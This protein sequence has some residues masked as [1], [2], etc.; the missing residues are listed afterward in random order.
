MIKAL[1]RI[2]TEEN[3]EENLM[4]A[5]AKSYRFVSLL[6][7]L[8]LLVQTMGIGALTPL[9]MVAAPRTA[10][11]AA[12]SASPGADF[13]TRP[14][15][16]ETP[17]SVARAQST[18]TGETVVITYTVRNTLSPLSLPEVADGATAAEKMTALAGFDLAADPNAMQNVVLVA[19]TTAAGNI[20]GSS[21]PATVDTTVD[22]D[23][24]VFQLGSLPPQAE[25]TLVITSSAP[26]AVSDATPLLNVTGWASLQGR[27]LSAQA[28]PAL[29][30]SPALA[31]WLIR[32]MDADTEDAEM[33]AALGQ[34][35]GAPADI[36]AFVRGFG[37][38]A[39]SG[40]LRGTRG[41]LW[42]EAG[43]SLDQANLLI[44]ML[45]A[46]GVPARYRHGTL[47]QANAQTLIASMF[48]APASVIGQVSPE[49]PVS[50][51]VNDAALIGEVQDHWW[52][53]AYVNG[54]WTDLDP[55]F[56]GASIG[57]RFTDQIAGDGTDR[58]AEVPDSFRPKVTIRLDVDSYN[59]FNAGGLPRTTTQMTH[60]FRVV[61][62][63][64]SAVNF[65][66]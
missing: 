62:V 33:L 48:R 27:A 59:Q 63:A 11:A 58:V 50:D 34:V 2:T 32:T 19:E 55:S 41:T 7:C 37:F 64:T 60:T 36:F 66:H 17:L 47:S 23:S 30:H 9:P 24:H 29:V 35:G 12:P 15:G 22:G 26:A 43:N 8:S 56:V 51:P 5:V 3:T 53:E 31:S 65:S 49:I 28:A 42:S 21:V 25:A 39:Y 16:F 40:S 38:E 1:Q 14:D 18:F 6:V 57:Q 54:A 45:R 52:V 4:Y 46:A 61:E 44:A 13:P 20:T 10:P